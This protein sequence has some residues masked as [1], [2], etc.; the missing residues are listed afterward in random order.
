MAYDRPKRQRKGDRLFYSGISPAEMAAD[1]AIAPLDRLATDMDR[2]WGIDQL[3]G[4]VSVETAEKYGSAMA[5]LNAALDAGDP[6]DVKARAEVCMRG[7]TAMDAEATRLGHQPVSPDYWEAEI[8]GFKFAVM[9]EGR[10]WMVHQEARPDLRFFSLR[11]VGV[12]LSALRIDNPIFAEVKKHFPQ[13]EIKSIAE[14]AA[15]D[16]QSLD[17]PIPF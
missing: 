11:E 13:A 14:R 9:R 7:L 12:A 10:N 6:E 17:D 3:P 2:K 15:P 4:L 1:Y 16:R 5:K 8:D